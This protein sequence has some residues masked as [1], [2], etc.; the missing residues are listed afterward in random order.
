MFQDEETFGGIDVIALES[1]YWSMIKKQRASDESIPALPVKILSSQSPSISTILPPTNFIRSTAAAASNI[2]LTGGIA[3]P[4]VVTTKSKMFSS[5]IKSCTHKPS[6]IRPDL[7][8]VAG[9]I[10]YSRVKITSEDDILVFQKNVQTQGTQYNIVLMAVNKITPDSG[11]F[12]PDLQDVTKVLIDTALD[13]KFLEDD[14]LSKDFSEAK[15]LLLMMTFG[16]EFIFQLLLI[17]HSKL[18]S[19]SLATINIP[20]YSTS[21]CLYKYAKAINN[22]VEVQLTNSRVYTTKVISYMYLSHLDSETHM[23][24]RDR[25]RTTIEMTPNPIPIR[26]QVPGLATALTY[27]IKQAPANDAY[28]NMMAD[29]CIECSDDDD[30]D[31]I[32][33]ASNYRGRQ[34]HQRH[35]DR[36]RRQP[37][38]D[39]NRVPSS[40]SSSLH[41]DRSS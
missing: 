28:V 12:H 41:Q 34:Q 20:K 24:T 8:D 9:F 5:T 40:S 7:I 4:D 17:K 39:K 1:E 22:Y 21:K 6:E 29:L 26:Y 11:I 23:N 25:I 30:D 14:V 15:N 13:T 38:Y 31:A 19:V 2:L 16:S 10:K 32:I 35:Y 3:L 18:T 33:N 27:L 37:R 36:N